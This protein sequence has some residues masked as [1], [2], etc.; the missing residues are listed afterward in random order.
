M[1]A[2]GETLLQGLAVDGETE[3]GGRRLHLHGAGEDPQRSRRLR[4][5]VGGA[6]TRASG[7]DECDEGDAQGEPAKPD[8]SSHS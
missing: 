7:S 2:D 6:A 5:L 3:V 8:Q 4:H 1:L